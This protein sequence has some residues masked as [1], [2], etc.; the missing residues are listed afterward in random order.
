ME[1]PLVIEVLASFINKTTANYY[2]LF[3]TFLLEELE[4]SKER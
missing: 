3:Q 1:T 2:F 4:R